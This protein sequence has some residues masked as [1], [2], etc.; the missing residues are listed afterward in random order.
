MHS[1]NLPMVGLASKCFFV[2][3]HGNVHT[4]EV[5]ALIKFLVLNISRKMSFH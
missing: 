1:A 5:L 4:T 3:V 2:S